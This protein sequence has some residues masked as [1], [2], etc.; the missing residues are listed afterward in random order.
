MKKTM[1]AAAVTSLMAVSAAAQNHAYW[2]SDTPTRGFASGIPFYDLA[3]T[4]RYQQFLA[5]ANLP[6]GRPLKIVEVAFGQNA[7]VGTFS[8]T[9]DFQLRLS[10][11]PTLLNPSR[12][13]ADNQA[14]CP[15]NM[16]DRVGF[17]Y[18]PAA[19]SWSDL[20]ADCHFGWDGKSNICIEIRFRGRGTLSFPSWGCMGDSSV[21]RVWANDTRSDNYGAAVGNDSSNSYGLKCRL[22]Y[23]TDHV[24]L[25][26]PTTTLA[27]GS[28]VTL[29]GFAPGESYRI[30]ASFG[31]S[32]FAVG[33]AKIGL[34]RDGLYLASIWCGAP[35]FKDYVGLAD[36]N[37]AASA[38]FTPPNLPALAGL[39][40]YH[41]A[42]GIGPSGVAGTNTAGTRLVP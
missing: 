1:L 34:D 3:K 9:G 8:C 10:N 24:C 26:A 30:A 16:I 33:P 2:P 18:A 38:T 22:A 4:Y 27:K 5:A 29:H 12:T 37:G 41:A 31:Q 7:I 25:A 17:S 42:V 6:S 14:P 15:T 32:P 39:C 36:R 11:T 35:I 21:P 20:G 28:S 19:S 23:V 13:F 40:V